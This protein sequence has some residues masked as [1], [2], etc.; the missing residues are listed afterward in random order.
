M[1]F[2]ANLRR[3]LSIRVGVDSTCYLG[4]VLITGIMVTQFPQDYPLWQRIVLGAGAGCLFLASMSV[5]QIPLNITALLLGVPLRNVTL[6]VFGGKRP[7]T[8]SGS[9]A[10][11]PW[12]G[13]ALAWS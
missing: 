5:S 11:R 6:F 3:I 8:T 10:P 4:I 2:R 9:Y 1:S 12:Q 13:G 7:A